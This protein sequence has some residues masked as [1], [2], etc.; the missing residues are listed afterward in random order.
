MEEANFHNHTMFY[1]NTGIIS[2]SFIN[3]NVYKHYF[4]A[5]SWH[6][7]RKTIFED[8]GLS[9]TK[10]KLMTSE[11]LRVFRFSNYV[12]GDSSRHT[13]VVAGTGLMK[14]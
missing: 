13:L 1:R 7:H 4:H 8:R 14:F 12:S 5:A 3:K 10:D 2:C 11:V 6:L 9:R